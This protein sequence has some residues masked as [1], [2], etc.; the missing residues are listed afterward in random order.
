MSEFIAVV[1]AGVMGQGIAQVSAAAGNR[2]VI[3][4][5]DQTRSRD[6]IDFVRRMLRRSAEKGQIR[7]EEAERACSNL[8]SCESIEEIKE[9]TLI[10][11]AA[12]E[13][14]DIKQKIFADLEAVVA[15]DTII[16]TNTSSL[17]VTQI[18]S[19]CA[20]PQRVAGLH[21]FNPVPL[22]KLVEII[23]GQLTDTRTIE[24][25]STYVNGVGH[26]SVLATDTPGFLVNH[27][28]R[29]FYTEGV[30][31]VGEGVCQ[32]IDVDRVARDALG[33]RMGPFELFDHTGL[34]VSY[35]VLK[36]IYHQYFE[37]PRF[38]PHPLLARQHAAGLFG[39]KTGRG[40]YR[41]EGAQRIEP[42]EEVGPD[43]PAKP[44]WVAPTHA[45]A[46]TLYKWF[47]ELGVPLD[48]RVS[49]SSD[50][51][52]VTSPE[53][54]DA[55]TSAHR[56]G[57]D[58]T[59]CIAIDT[60]IWPVK[61]LTLMPTVVT[62]REVRDSLAHM[63]RSRSVQ[64]TVIHDSPGFIGQR[65]V[66]SIVNLACDIAQQ[67]IGSPRDIDRAVKLGLGY[68]LGPLEWGDKLGSQRILN[69]LQQLF[70]FYGDPRYRP[71][72]WLKRRAM[73]QVSLLTNES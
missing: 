37:E 69:I 61:R 6:A 8:S 4:D 63:L 10:I 44:V 68:P 62:R 58:M 12:A 25:L 9:A 59:R 23:P 27:A 39:K 18:A 47:Q 3:F 1:G 51:I 14:L 65:V 60:M 43:E 52:I 30:R 26:A 53:G 2:V 28:G 24:R 64:A 55:T 33:F 46:N 66:A 72:Q 20:R 71:S 32:V 17:I 5:V 67:R 42:I 13:N 34:D 49:P 45:G 40:F 21:F 57:L 50:S 19:A 16:A 15:D 11:E 48:D 35:P 38:R 7:E 36:Q 22:M 70:D 41:Y 73:A 54:E 56:L 31:I 29:A